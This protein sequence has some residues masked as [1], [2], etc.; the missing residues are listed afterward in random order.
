MAKQMTPLPDAKSVRVNPSPQELKELAAKMPNARETRYGNLNVQTEVLARSKASTFLVL[1]D[2]ESSSQQAISRD[3]G[4]RIAQL[5]DDYIAGRDMLVVDGFI[6]DD[7]DFRTPARLY[8]EESNANVAGMQRQ[9]YFPVDDR[10]SFE[11][12]L[13]VVYTPNL[14]VEGYPN[15]RVITV[16]LERGVTR[17]CNSDYFGESKKGGLRMWN[18]LVYDRGGLPLHAGWKGIPPDPGGPAG[19]SLGS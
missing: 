10:D 7:P 9:L 13:T 15:D 3:E 2:P 11:P 18:K 14:V 8:I 12:E 19:P 5:Q 4:D 6:G 1:D 17:V 16:D